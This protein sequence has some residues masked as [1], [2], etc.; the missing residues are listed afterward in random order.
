MAYLPRTVSATGKIRA[1]SAAFL[2]I[3]GNPLTATRT[4]NAATSNYSIVG[5]LSGLANVPSQNFQLIP[6]GVT[7]NDTVTFSDGGAGGVFN[8]TS[9]T[10]INSG[11]VQTFTYTPMGTGVYPLTLTSST[12]LTINGNGFYYTATTNAGAGGTTINYIFGSE[13]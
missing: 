4:S 13:G 3:T 5:P 1:Q 2:P 8:P 11:T 6:N 7:A 10:Q 12:P 9:L